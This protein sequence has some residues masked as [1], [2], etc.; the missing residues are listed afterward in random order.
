M[1]SGPYRRFTGS[2]FLRSLLDVVAIEWMDVLLHFI[3][4]VFAAFFVFAV[5][6]N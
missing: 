1:L 3:V 2:M 4:C 5:I 6:F